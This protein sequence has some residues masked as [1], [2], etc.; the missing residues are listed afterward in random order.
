MCGMHTL[1]ARKNGKL[2]QRFFVASKLL[3]DI[4][5]M[6]PTDMFR[7]E[8]QVDGLKRIEAIATEFN[9]SIELGDISNAKL[10]ISEL[11]SLVSDISQHDYFNFK[12]PMSFEKYQG[13][14]LELRKNVFSEYGCG[15]S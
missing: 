9:S 8:Y 1:D 7:K 5:A 13:L 2:I 15:S 12:I 4:I 3:N 14:L 11:V 10:K 6:T